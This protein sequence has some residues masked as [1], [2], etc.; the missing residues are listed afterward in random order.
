MLVSPL[1]SG[2]LLSF[3]VHF[4]QPMTGPHFH[5]W[6]EGKETPKRVGNSPQPT[7]SQCCHHGR[8]SVRTMAHSLGFRNASE[9]NVLSQRSQDWGRLPAKLPGKRVAAQEGQGFVGSISMQ[10]STW[11]SPGSPVLSRS[12]RQGQ[13]RVA[14]KPTAVK[15]T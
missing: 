5:M 1:L 3:P 13:G 7:Q 14:A 4:T 12:L 8:P 15:R 10:R 9:R 2:C 6:T 11:N